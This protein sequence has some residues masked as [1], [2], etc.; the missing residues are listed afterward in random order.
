MNRQTKKCDLT[1]ELESLGLSEREWFILEGRLGPGEPLTLREL[2]DALDLSRE[3]VRQIQTTAVTQVVHSFPRLARVCNLL[4]VRGEQLWDPFSAQT[5]VDSAVASCQ[6]I[7]SQGGWV[8]P[9]KLDVLR[10]FTA[11][12][13]SIEWG[14]TRAIRA[15]PRVSYAMCGLDKVIANHISAAKAEVRREHEL[16]EQRR[17]WSYK[18]LASAVLKESGTPLHWR[19]IASRAE[20]LGHRKDFNVSSFF[21]ALTF[22]PDTFARVG[23]GTY[24][25]VEDGYRRV[26]N[27]DDIIADVLQ[28]ANKP[29]SYGELLQDVNVIRQIKPASLQMYLDTHV[30]FYRSVEGTYG[31]RAWLPPP[32]KQTLR[33]PLWQVEDS[34]SF[35]RVDRERAR[36]CNVDSI[37]EQDQ[38]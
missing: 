23:Q 18:R 9:T 3:R 27:Y 20:H 4:E 24:G 17:V 6:Q 34:D 1:E 38:N 8:H 2:A 32:E 28:A 35:E 12:R 31:L 7:L 19:E 15:W 14:S 16:E 30:R 26:E 37:I 13:A 25:L 5:S 10:L 36:G 29:L 22:D 11:V 21:N 33:T